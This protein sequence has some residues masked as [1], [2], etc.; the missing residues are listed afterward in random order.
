MSAASERE[1]AGGAERARWLDFWN[2]Q[3]TFSDGFMAGNARLFFERSRPLLALGPRDDVLDLGSGSGHLTELMAPLVR[4]VCAVDGAPRTVAL[5]RERLHAH[6]NID[7]ACVDLAGDAPPPARSGAGYSVIV[8]HSVLQYL[9]DHEA[10]A[11]LFGR[12]AELAAPSARMLFADLPGEHALWRD[13]GSQVLHGLRRGFARDVLWALPVATVAS[14]RR[15]RKQSGVLGFTRAELSRLG[16]VLGGEAQILEGG[17]TANA[18][19]R[20]LFVQRQR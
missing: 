11:R 1:G 3:R 14:Y 12:L 4:S 18:S 15:L 17:L 6:A 7:W 13:V 5:G 9:P 10:V 19:R 16:G 2:Q 20:H 8:C